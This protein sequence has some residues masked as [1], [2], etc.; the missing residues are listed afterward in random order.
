[1][2]TD[3]TEPSGGRG[4]NSSDWSGPGWGLA[5]LHHQLGRGRLDDF[6]AAV[7]LAAG[8]P[9]RENNS[10]VGTVHSIGLGRVRPGRWDAKV[11]LQDAVWADRFGS[12]HLLEQMSPAYCAN[13]L[14]HLR[15]LEDPLRHAAKELVGR[16]FTRGRLS[17][18]ERDRQVG[19]TDLLVATWTSATPLG[20][21]LEICA[22]ASARSAVATTS[23]EDVQ[24]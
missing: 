24:T 18:N 4:F 6:A 1:M 19:L 7:L 12:V 15:D 16:E 9:L 5:D 22:S 14:T 13:V 23:A 3:R 11:L 8:V 20:H 17:P 2:A 21:R 10:L